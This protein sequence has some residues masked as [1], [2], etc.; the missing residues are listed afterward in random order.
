MAIQP[1][2]E[3]DRESAV[4][5]ARKWAFDRNP[6][7]G[8]F[9]TMGGD[10]TNFTS[11][12]LYA[13]GASFNIDSDY[14]WYYKNLDNRAP[15]WSGVEALHEFLISNKT[16]NGPMAVPIA[17][18]DVEKGD[19]VQLRFQGNDR[20]SHS[21]VVTDLGRPVGSNNLFTVGITTHSL[22]SRSRPLGTYSFAEMRPLH[23]TGVR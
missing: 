23:I 11:Q 5:Y 7:W 14:G 22:D 2:K 19:I 17:L 16:G 8:D 15:A 12:V 1:A 18:K 3:Y 21:L 10:C 13:G 4:Q 20:F 6:E 9:E